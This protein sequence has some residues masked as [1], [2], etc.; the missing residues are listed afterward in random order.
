MT[1]RTLLWMVL[2]VVAGCRTTQP[3]T[4][5]LPASLPE[6]P[7]VL[8]PWYDGWLLGGGKVLWWLRDKRPIHRWTLPAAVQG[9]V[10]DP[11]GVLWLGTGAGLVR[12]T[13]PT[14]QP[15]RVPL[16]ALN[17]F[18]SVTTLTLDAQQRLWLVPRSMASSCAPTR[19]GDRC[20]PLRR[21]TRWPPRPTAPYGWEP[22]SACSDRHPTAGWSIRK[23]ARP[24]TVCP[25]TSSNGS[26][27]CLRGSG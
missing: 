6:P 18:P 10:V 13:A 26:L 19:A 12:L 2:L 15:E 5:T 8:L 7:T 1:P 17:R 3:V 21:C 11:E 23:K 22:V 16:P 20:W 25:T 9:G 24:T 14:A 27:H 4:V